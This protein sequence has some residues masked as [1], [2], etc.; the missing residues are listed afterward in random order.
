MQEIAVNYIAAKIDVVDRESFEKQI[1]EIVKRY[2]GYQVSVESIKDDKATRAT[3]NKLIKQISD[4]R[5]EI[6]NEFNIPLKDF[7]SWVKKAT[8]PLEKVVES[9][10]SGVKEVEENIRQ[11]LT[12]IIRAQFEI[13]TKDTQIDPRIFEINIP[14]LC[15]SSY[16]NSLNEPKQALL[17]EIKVLVDREKANMA[18]L[19]SDKNTITS[20]AFDNNLPDTPYLTMLDQGEELN[21]ILEILQKDIKAEKAKKESEEKRAVEEA[22]RKAELLAEQEREYV[23]KQLESEMGMVPEESE[24]DVKNAEFKEIVPEN[25]PIVSKS[26]EKYHCTIDIIFDSIEE[27]NRWKEV[28]V[29]NGFGDFHALKFE[30]VQVTE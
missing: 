23:T 19:E 3:L 2:K 30:K 22:K 10:N 8:D 16:F 7:E 27:K 6:K 15:K 28:M 24:N 14:T 21:F 13:A 29:A 11:L 4:R 12:G 9:I 1:N 25:D 26:I 5:I 17:D 18:R 20:F